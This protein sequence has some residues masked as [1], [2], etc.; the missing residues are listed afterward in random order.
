M[1][2]QA[3]ALAVL[4]AEDRD[5]VVANAN[6]A[7]PDESQIRLQS[8][9]RRGAE[10]ALVLGWNRRGPEIVRQ[11]TSY[12]AAGS[13]I[14]IAAQSP[15]VEKAVAELQAKGRPV[16][17]EARSA[18]ARDRAQLEA[19]RPATFDHV[20]VLAQTDHG[21]AQAADTSTLV[22]LLHLR[23]IA[24]REKAHFTVVSEIADV[25]N[26]ELADVTQ[27]DDFV[28]SH[29]LV[30][31]MLAQSAENKFASAIFG[32]LLSAEG[33]ELYM[34]PIKSFVTTNE[35]VNFYTIAEAAMRRGETAIGY[36]QK[37]RGPNSVVINPNKSE[38]IEFHDGDMIVVLAED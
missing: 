31:L 28:V 5:S 7:A 15:K 4:V 25:R 8:R 20:L 2:I 11:M 24:E 12:M 21:H 14:V 35:P 38:K 6:A 18:D 26:R 33:S 17:L 1:K 36:L 9:A 3:G 22:T 16:T 23:R 30:S 27:A 29:R 34:R 32:D 19:L 10:R 13:S 37:A